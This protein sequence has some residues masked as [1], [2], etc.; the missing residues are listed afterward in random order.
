MPWEAPYQAPQAPQKPSYQ[1]APEEIK[2]AGLGW[3]YKAFQDEHEGQTPEQ[4]YKATGEGLAEALA[5]KE[6]A[7]NFAEDNGRPPTDDEW[8][9]W[10][11]ES[12]TGGAPPGEEPEEAGEA[13]PPLYVPPPTTWKV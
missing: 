10:W 8:R 9:W 2:G 12:R 11:F 5:D 7:E 4:Y 13:R 3:W 6:W 1:E